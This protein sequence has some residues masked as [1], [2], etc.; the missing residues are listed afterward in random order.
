PPPVQTAAATRSVVA[1]P[2]PSPPDESSMQ[3]AAV[4][5]P[6]VPAAE[7]V[8]SV[9]SSTKPERVAAQSDEPS[10]SPLGDWQTEGKGTVRIARCGD[11]LCGHALGS[12]NEKGDAI[13]INMKAKGGRQW[14]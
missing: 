13:L 10:D 4:P 14:A 6:P 3:L 9:Q 12:A 8:G 11:A 2:P 5:S 1:E 7:T